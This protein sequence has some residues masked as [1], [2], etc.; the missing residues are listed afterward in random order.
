MGY[1][2]IVSQGFT[3]TRIIY[4]DFYGE[5]LLKMVVNKNTALYSIC[6]TAQTDQGC[7]LC[8]LNTLVC[9]KCNTNLHYIFDNVTKT[10]LA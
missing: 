2:Y 7:T 5:D 8:T 6:T 1:N 9:L 3:F 4:T 10:C